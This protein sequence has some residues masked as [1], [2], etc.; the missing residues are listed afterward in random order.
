V[1]WSQFKKIT[2]GAERKKIGPKVE[3]YKFGEAPVLIVAPHIGGEKIEWKAEGKTVIFNMCEW[4]TDILAAKAAR[5]IG[6]HLMVSRIPRNKVDFARSPEDLG[7]GITARL[8]HSRL[9]HPVLMPVHADTS[10]RPL[11]EKFH[12]KI[13]EIRP[14]F[15]LTYHGMMNKKYDVLLGFG[16]RKQYIGGLVNA[17]KFRSMVVRTLPKNPGLKVGIS[18]KRLTGESDYVLKSHVH[19]PVRGALVEFNK[20]GRSEQ[21]P[22]SEYEQ[23]AVAI[24]RVAKEWVE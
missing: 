21:E 18:W 9:E 4:A 23:L 8:G 7:R 2:E 17:H 22:S 12:K 19:K 3:H 15:I 10:G 1:A 13:D 16:R 20:K 11:L 14:K 6:G 5:E 24:A